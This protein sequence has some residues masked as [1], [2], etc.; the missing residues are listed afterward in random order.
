L[1]EYQRQG[2]EVGREGFSGSRS[3]GLDL[4]KNA[5][6]IDLRHAASMGFVA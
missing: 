6:P 3:G 4:L 1:E 2:V 5:V